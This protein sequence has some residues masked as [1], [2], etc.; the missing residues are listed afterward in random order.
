M[1]IKKKDRQLLKDIVT[2]FQ[3]ALQLGGPKNGHKE[4]NKDVI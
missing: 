4:I 3:K 2:I 1:L